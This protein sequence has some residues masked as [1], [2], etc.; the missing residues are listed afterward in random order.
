M[1]LKTKCSFIPRCAHDLIH[2]TGQ[3][4]CFLVPYYRFK[5][6]VLFSRD[7]FLLPRSKGK[8]ELRKRM[9]SDFFFFVILCAI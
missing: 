6:H 1:L 4:T 2:D 8:A 9:Y 5:M 3:V 7:Y